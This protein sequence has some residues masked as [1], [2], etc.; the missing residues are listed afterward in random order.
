MI[1]SHEGME[2]SR[3]LLDQCQWKTVTKMVMKI[4]ARSGRMCCVCVITDGQ[5]KGTNQNIQ[6]FQVP[7]ASVIQPNASGNTHTQDPTCAIIVC[8]VT[9]NTVG[10]TLYSMQS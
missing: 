4:Q 2:N 10:T 1:H 6:Q 7:G 5:Q 8:H 9:A 3:M